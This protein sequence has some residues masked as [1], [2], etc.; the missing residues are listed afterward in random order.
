[1]SFRSTRAPRPRLTPDGFEPGATVVRAATDDLDARFRP[2]SYDKATRTVVAVFSAG[3]RVARWGVF[4]ELAIS[5]EAVDLNRVALGQ[6]RALDTH[7]QSSIDDVRGVVTEA[8]FEGGHLVGRIRFADTEEGRRAEGMVA[9]GEITGS[10]YE[11]ASRLG[12]NPRIVGEMV[13]LFSHK[14]DFDRDLKPGD[15]F[16]MVFDRKITES[17]KTIETGALE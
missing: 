17:G 1:M 11:S 2:A 12:A 9:R 6:C 16:T 10:L 3:S 4:E 7:A 13:K 8:W 15:A 14:I 5:P